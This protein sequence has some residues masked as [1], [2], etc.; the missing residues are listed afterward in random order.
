MDTQL[1]PHLVCLLAAPAVMAAGLTFDGVSDVLVARN[2]LEV[3]D[4]E[5]IRFKRFGD[6]VTEPGRAVGNGEN[7]I[8]LDEPGSLPA[9]ARSTT[10]TSGSMRRGG[11]SAAATHGPVTTSVRPARR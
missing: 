3:N 8:S 10:A 9:T 5:G 1:T 6:A 2:H 4:F 11:G 7:G